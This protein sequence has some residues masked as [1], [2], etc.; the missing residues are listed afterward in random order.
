V[1]RI[2]THPGTILKKEFLVLFGM[3]AKQLA[4]AVGVPPN[5]ITELI[6]ARRGVTADTAIR[7]SRYFGTT[8]KFW[9]NLQHAHDLSKAETE[10]DYSKIPVRAA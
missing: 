3:S 1:P 4:E 8:A 5:R 9:L 7:L 2:R 10:T 6:R